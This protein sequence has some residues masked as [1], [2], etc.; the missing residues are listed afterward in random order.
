M[1]PQN[2]PFLF[3]FFFFYPFHISGLSNP[4][5]ATIQSFLSNPSPL[6]TIPAFPEQ[7][8][9][10]GCPLDLPDELFHGI[11]TAC[12]SGGNRQLHKSRCCPVLAAWLYSAYSATA[13]GRAGRVTPAVAGRTSSSYLPLLPDDSETCVDDLGKALKDKGIE[14]VKPNETCDVVYCYCGIR[15]HPLSCPQAFSTNQQGKLV[16][17]KRV[18]RLER[19]C[20]SSS[21]NV[22]QFPGLGGCSKCLNSLYRLNNKKTLNSSKSEDRTTKMH[23]KDCQL[24]G[25][26]WLLAKNRTAYIHTVSAVL[27]AMMMNADGSNPQSCTI[28][29]DGIP[30]AVGS[31]EISSNSLSISHQA[32][33]YVS[34]V[35]FVI[36]LFHLLLFASS[37]KF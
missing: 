9:V 3:F 6:A 15:L 23:N 18:K 13:L 37:T 5:P 31:S 35:V 8:N 27:R 2:L 26:T 11:K 34:V 29:S 24:M 33:I 7:S 17:D 21:T 25:L 22:N 4:D 14:L 28:N 10:E 36:C 16:G 20:L 12:G 32:P 19:N 30:L 1:F